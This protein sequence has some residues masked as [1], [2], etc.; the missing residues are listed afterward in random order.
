MTAT[1]IQSA[2]LDMGRR[3][4]EASRELNKL[5]TAQKNDILRAMADEI[6]AREQTILAA[7]AED[8]KNAARS[9]ASGRDCGCRA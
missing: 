9:E 2:I 3:A 7:N 4:R 6:V 8:L 5:T 1:E